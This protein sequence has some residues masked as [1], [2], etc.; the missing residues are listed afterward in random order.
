MTVAATPTIELDVDA[1]IKLALFRAGMLNAGA[2]PDAGQLSIGKMFL[3]DILTSVQSKGV[4]MRATERYEQATVAGQ[5]YVDAP[6]DTSSVEKGAIVRNTNGAEFEMQLYSRRDYMTRI[7]VKDTQGKPNIYY[8]EQ[9]PSGLF[10]IFLW[11]VPTTDWPTIVYPRERKLRDVSEGNVTIDLD[12]R[13]SLP[14]GLMLA[15]EF[16]RHYGR[17]ARQQALKD[18]LREALGDAGDNETER[19]DMTFTIS[20]TPWDN[21]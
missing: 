19:G 17:V 9:L 15:M 2:N 3:R 4:I 11:L 21:W 8:A 10:R 12:Q 18:D 7:P 16:A 5:A 13:W 20:S 1:T 6:S 14:V